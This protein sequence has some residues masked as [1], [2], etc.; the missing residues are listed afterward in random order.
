MLDLH[1]RDLYHWKLFTYHGSI[2]TLLTYIFGPN[3]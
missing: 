1:V 2:L 3:Y